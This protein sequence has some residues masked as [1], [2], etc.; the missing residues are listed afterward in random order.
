MDVL[1]IDVSLK[2]VGRAWEYVFHF[3]VIDEPAENLLSRKILPSI[4]TYHQLT[5]IWF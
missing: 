4:N 5:E 1:I 2:L 3:L